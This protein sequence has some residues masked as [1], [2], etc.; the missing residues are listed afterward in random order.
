MTKTTDSPRSLPLLQDQTP[1]SDGCGCGGCGCGAAD[2]GSAPK[3]AI[4]NSTDGENPLTTHSYV[5]SGMTCGHCAGAVTSQLK[6]L[7]GVTDVNVE[8][9]AGGTS[10]VTITSAEPLDET[11]VVEALD[12]AGD[13]KLV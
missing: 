8:L 5:V 1:D 11:R 9:V 13:Y 4:A 12:E 10:T 3:P 2:T 6:M 7:D